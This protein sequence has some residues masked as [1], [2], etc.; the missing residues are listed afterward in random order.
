METQTQQQQILFS[1]ARLVI[2]EFVWEDWQTVH[3][4]AR[5]PEVSQYQYWGPNKEKDTQTF[6]KDALAYRQYRPRLQYELCV[7]LYNGVHIGGCSLFVESARQQEA[8]I[9]YLLH[10]AYWNQGFA[11]EI[12]THLL[13][14]G[15]ETLQLKK[16]KATCDTRNIASQRVLEKTGFVQTAYTE[17]GFMKN[18]IW[19]STYQYVYSLKKE[20]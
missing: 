13:Q 18:R 8:T 12:V 19:Q 15:Q 6:I 11:T 14:Y 2:R 9:G 3:A 1:T 10:P 4:Y 16:I 5:M 20:N 17:K 7:C